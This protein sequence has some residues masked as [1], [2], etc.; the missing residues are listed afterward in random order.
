M[1]TTLWSIAASSVLAMSLA[2]G[3]E[4]QDR[5]DAAIAEHGTV[6]AAIET[7]VQE[8]LD[9]LFNRLSASGDE[10]KAEAVAGF[11]EKFAVDGILPDEPLLRTIRQKAKSRFLKATQDR[12]AAY[13]KA[14]AEYSRAGD[15]NSADET[16]RA[17]QEFEREISQSPMSFR[18]SNQGRP[19]DRELT[20]SVS[21]N[22]SNTDESAPKVASEGGNATPAIDSPAGSAARRKAIK[23][24]KPGP[25]EEL[26]AV[27]KSGRELDVLRDH[28]ATTDQKAEAVI[29]VFSRI[30]DEYPPA[31]WTYADCGYLSDFVIRE[32]PNTETIVYPDR[33]RYGDEGLEWGPVSSRGDFTGGLYVNVSSPIHTD[34]PIEPFGR[35]VRSRHLIAWLA[36]SD[37]PKTLIQRAEFLRQTND[38]TSV[39]LNFTD[40]DFKAWLGCV[41]CKDPEALKQVIQ[42]LKRAKLPLEAAARFAKNNGL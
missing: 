28:L 17:L 12:R 26:V 15:A 33:F 8:Q 40:D 9:D 14:I 5:L 1:R 24:P 11:R 38:L 39:N 29:S 20:G 22:N 2:V 23:P 16:K 21:E 6:L 18:A 30:S 27:I 31:K 36:I 13:R 25:S 37:G 19:N 7:D 41:G 3:D 34:T 35:Y 42:E 32:Y 4:V 10:G